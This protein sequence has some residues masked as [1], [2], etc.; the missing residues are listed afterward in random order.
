MPNSLLNVLSSLHSKE[1]RTVLIASLSRQ[2]KEGSERC[3]DLPEV[4]QLMVGRAKF[5]LQSES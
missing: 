4:T 1:A 2:A 3:S 5:K